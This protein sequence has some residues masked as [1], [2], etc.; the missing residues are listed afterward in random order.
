MDVPSPTY[1]LHATYSQPG[2]DCV[3]IHHYDLY[4]LQ[5]DGR[6]FTRLDLKHSLETGV[7]L[8]EWPER[9]AGMVPEERLELHLRCASG[10]ENGDI[11]EQSSDIE[12]DSGRYIRIRWVGQRWGR[13][14][15]ALADH[16]KTRGSSLGLEV[17]AP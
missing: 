11:N 16:V 3:D 14:V 10:P 1:L 4:R 6:D 15:L 13:L 5:Q 8:I 9:L 17:C 12:G 7:C 2:D